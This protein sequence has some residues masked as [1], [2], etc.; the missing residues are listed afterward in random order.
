MCIIS[1]LSNLKSKLILDIDSTLKINQI[2]N[3]HKITSKFSYVASLF[4]FKARD[5][6]SD[7]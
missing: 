4:Q 2:Q 3:K 7:Y 5:Y 6:I 1:N